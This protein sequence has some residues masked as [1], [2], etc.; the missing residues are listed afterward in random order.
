MSTPINIL[1]NPETM[2]AFEEWIDHPSTESFEVDMQPLF[3]DSSE[4]SEEDFINPDRQDELEW[5]TSRIT[6][7]FQK[8]IDPRERYEMRT[9]VEKNLCQVIGY[10]GNVYK[11]A[12]PRQKGYMPCQ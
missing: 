4:S 10:R 5:L 2:A 1:Q 8:I 9:L 11:D 6:H 3:T 7:V 12:T